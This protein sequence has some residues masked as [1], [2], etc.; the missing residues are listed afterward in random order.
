MFLLINSIL[1]SP[2]RCTKIV[3][4]NLF[5]AE[6]VYYFN[7]VNYMRL[8]WQRQCFKVLFLRIACSY[9]NTY[10]IRLRTMIIPRIPPAKARLLFME[11]LRT[12][13]KPSP[14]SARTTAPAHFITT[15]FFPISSRV[16]MKLSMFAP[17]YSSLLPSIAFRSVTSS[18]Y[19]R[20]PPTGIPC[21][22]LET[23][24]PLGLIRRAM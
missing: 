7:I 10:L 1:L 16:C 8:F 13:M 22:I 21:A 15:G 14:S 3:L 20:S 23:F 11:C 9:K 2:L 5:C 18:A 19:S 4:F 6:Y 17:L 12:R 24:M